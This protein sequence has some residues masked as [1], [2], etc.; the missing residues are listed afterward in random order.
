M[1]NLEAQECMRILFP[2]RLF[3]PISLSNSEILHFP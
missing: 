2:V 3:A 1:R